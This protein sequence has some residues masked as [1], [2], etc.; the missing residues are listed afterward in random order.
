[1]AFTSVA[2][3]AKQDHVNACARMDSN[4]NYA[5]AEALKQAGMHAKGLF[6]TG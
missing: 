6:A 3:V 4:S 1:M 2:L 5:L